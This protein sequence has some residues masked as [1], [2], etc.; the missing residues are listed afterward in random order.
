MYTTDGGRLRIKHTEYEQPT[1]RPPV[2]AGAIR[3]QKAEAEHHTVEELDGAA[4]EYLRLELTIE[5]LDP[6]L[7]R[8]A[9]RRRRW[10]A[11]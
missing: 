1:I 5:P 8:R 10:D 9:A 6:P 4:S 7:Q 3:Y 2:K 11:L